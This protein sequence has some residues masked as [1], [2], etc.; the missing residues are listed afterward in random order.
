MADSVFHSHALNVIMVIMD[1]FQTKSLAT[2]SQNVLSGETPQAAGSKEREVYSLAT[3]AL[4]AQSRQATIALNAQ[5]QQ[6]TIALHAQSRQ[7]TIA[8]HAQSRQATIALHAQFRQATIALHA[9]FRQFPRY[10]WLHLFDT[11]I[12]RIVYSKWTATDSN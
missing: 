12:I 1:R 11:E 10:I 9:Q 3:I 2:L 6:A 7:A 4:H 8:L 5:S